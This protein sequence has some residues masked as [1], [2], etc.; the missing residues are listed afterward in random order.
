MNQEETK[1]PAKRRHRSGARGGAVRR[2]AARGRHD[3]PTRA[4]LRRSL[5]GVK[6]ALYGHFD[7]VEPVYVPLLEHMAPRESDAL[8]R[9]RHA[10][11]KGHEQ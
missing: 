2:R 3:A 9:Q 10:A 11:V 6:A 7:E 1:P 8:A 4:E 5:I